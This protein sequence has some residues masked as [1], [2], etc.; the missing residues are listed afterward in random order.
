MNTSTQKTKLKVNVGC[1]Q[2]EWKLKLQ[3]VLR[4]FVVDGNSGSELATTFFFG[5]LLINGFMYDTEWIWQNALL[6]VSCNCNT[7]VP[8]HCY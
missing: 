3:T 6:Y 7:H 5:K 1:F 8:L 2:V 4:V